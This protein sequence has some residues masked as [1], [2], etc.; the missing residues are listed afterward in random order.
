MSEVRNQLAVI[1]KEN[2]K[3]NGQRG[4]TKVLCE[5]KTSIRKL[6]AESEKGFR[7]LNARQRP[8]KIG[9]NSSSATSRSKCYIVYGR[10]AEL[11]RVPS[12]KRNF[13]RVISDSSI[14][15]VNNDMGYLTTLKAFR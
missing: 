13:T 1:S 15:S 8:S 7:F 12:G 14:R 3:V 2:G 11:A 5:S 10:P 4:Y 9:E 6:E